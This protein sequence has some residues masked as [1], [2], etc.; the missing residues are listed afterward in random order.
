[1]LDYLMQRR[2]ERDGMGWGWM[3]YEWMQSDAELPLFAREHLHQH[4]LFGPLCTHWPRDIENFQDYEDNVFRF[5]QCVP[6]DVSATIPLVRPGASGEHTR[7]PAYYQESISW[8][9]HPPYCSL[10]AIARSLQSTNC[11]TSPSFCNPPT[12]PTLSKLKSNPT[13]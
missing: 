8:R 5:Q 6:E 13:T 3:G 10:V 11:E 1:L 4:Q 9:G 2:R 7:H 12:D